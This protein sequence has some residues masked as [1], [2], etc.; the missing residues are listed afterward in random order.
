YH[1][2]AED[3]SRGSLRCCG[4]GIQCRAPD[5]DQRGGGL[6]GL[7]RGRGRGRRAAVSAATPSQ[8]AEEAEE[9]EEGDVMLF[10]EVSDLVQIFSLLF[11]AATTVFLAWIGYLTVKLKEQQTTAATAVADV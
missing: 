8:E 4:N 2:L 5:Q 10:A 9:G 3:G 1:V 11:S 7:R 6:L